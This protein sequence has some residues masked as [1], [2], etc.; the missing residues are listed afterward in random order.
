MCDLQSPQGGHTTK[1]SPRY[2]GYQVER[3]ISV[4]DKINR[5]SDG[6]RSDRLDHVIRFVKLNFCQ[7]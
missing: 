2:T 3:E 5:N 4:K 1:H 7:A 6:G